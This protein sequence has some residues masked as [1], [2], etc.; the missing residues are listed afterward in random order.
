MEFK[1]ISDTENP[2][3]NRREI[4]GEIHVDVTPS[5]DEVVKL[6]A[7]KFSTH[8]DT[9]KIRTIKGS[10]GARVFIIVA[11]IYKS[12]KEKDEVELKKKKELESERKAQDAQKQVE[13]P[14]E[15]KSSEEPKQ[16]N[17]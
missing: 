10:F 1:I 7:E 15:E 3:F 9:I 11:N 5:R 13:E 2:L 12:K 4:E 8:Q 16:E 6:L 14:A 17:E